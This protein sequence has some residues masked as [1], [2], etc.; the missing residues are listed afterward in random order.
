V[1]GPGER[2]ASRID[3]DPNEP[4]AP[5]AFDEA[6]E[7]ID[8]RERDEAAEALERA[9]AVAPAEGIGYRDRST[10][11]PWGAFAVKAFEAIDWL[12]VRLSAGGFAVVGNFEEAL[13]CWRAAIAAGIRDA[14]TL[15]LAAG[16]GALGL[17]LV[18][19]DVGARF[20]TVPGSEAPGG[21][22]S[23]GDAPG[24]EAP[25]GEAR[26][27]SLQAAA[28]LVWRSLLMWIG[29]YALIT[30]SAWMGS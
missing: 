9:E 28:G 30:V 16:G 25:G 15:L 29:L 14:R 10:V 26:P 27:A 1:R 7:V 2:Y 23:G 4:V 8:L 5:D 21:E 24:F 19:A 3:L 18:D 6:V 17:R 12:P 11:S 20:E 22:A 13:Y